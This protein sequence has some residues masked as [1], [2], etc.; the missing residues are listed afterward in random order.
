[1]S[2]EIRLRDKSKTD[3]D[4]CVIKWNWGTESP[5]PLDQPEN[6]GDAI[7]AKGLH[8]FLAIEEPFPVWMGY[9]LEALGY[10]INSDEDCHSIREAENDDIIDFAL[11]IRFAREI[12]LMSE[13]DESSSALR[14]LEELQWQETCRSSNRTLDQMIQL[15]TD[16]QFRRQF[17]NAYGWSFPLPQDLTE[18][19][20]TQD[21]ADEQQA[22]NN[23][24]KLDSI[25][26]ANRHIMLEAPTDFSNLRKTYLCRA[27]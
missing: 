7:S 12:V 25:I 3:F 8:A 10:A 19:G 17:I 21:E 26:E 23:V 11:S 14:C 13:S 5:S 15:L 6:I 1:M 2:L 20:Y 4:G 16:P 22:M 18:N 24:I 9:S 27:D